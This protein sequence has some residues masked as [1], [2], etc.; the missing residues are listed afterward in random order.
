VPLIVIVLR[1]ATGDRV[2]RA[3]VA[4]VALGFAGVAL[5]LLP[6][7]RPDGATLAGML[8]LLGAAVMWAGGSFAASRIDLPRHP[9]VTTGWQMLLGGVIVTGAGVAAGESS[10][11]HPGAFSGDSLLAFAYLVLVGSIV[12]FTAYAWLLQHVPVSKVS[13]YAYV[14]PAIAIF[15]GWLILHETVTGVTLGGAAIIV[16]AVAVVVRAEGRARVR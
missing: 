9:L 11:L 3:S 7:E 13:T 8:A 4:G 10:D 6:G 14:N 15:L 1:R 16:A 5:L 12:A 2:A